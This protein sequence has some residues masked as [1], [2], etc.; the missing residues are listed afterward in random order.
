MN[1]TANM[2]KL[3]SAAVLL[4]ILLDV[5]CG[6]TVDLSPLE[7]K[8]DPPGSSSG[9]G[10]AHSGGGGAPASAGAP[11][12]GG[13]PTSGGAVCSNPASVAVTQGAA[14]YTQQCG[15]CHGA[16]A[17]GKEGPNITMS[18]TAG[19][20]DWTYQQFRDAVRLSVRPNGA[21][22]CPLMTR[23]SPSDISDAS[24]QDLYAYLQCRP[25]SDTLNRG[26][27]CP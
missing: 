13:A 17:H 3:L 2:N 9:A 27:Y 5:G 6:G 21:E 18:R 11:A 4:G 26:T 22:L 10:A 7:P 25:I 19:I 16:D 12:S 14:V 23:F 15:V 20:G 8:A 24:M 1:M